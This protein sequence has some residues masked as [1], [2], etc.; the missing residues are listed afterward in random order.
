MPFSPY[1]ALELE[2]VLVSLRAGISTM[3]TTPDGVVRVITPDQ[4][5]AIRFELAA[6]RRAQTLS[7][8][9]A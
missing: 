4:L 6:F 5:D 1:Y 7:P 3:L 8:L 9:I 2:R